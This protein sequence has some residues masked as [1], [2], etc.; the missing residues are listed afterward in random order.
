MGNYNTGSKSNSGCAAFLLILFFG[1]IIYTGIRFFSD[2]SLYKT[3]TSAYNANDLETAYLKYDKISDQFHIFDLGNY[4]KNAAAGVVACASREYKEAEKLFSSYKYQEAFSAF[5]ALIER[6]LEYQL[7]D[8]LSLAQE[9]QKICLE[10]IR[11]GIQD[12]YNKAKCQVVISD[13]KWMAEHELE[14]G[15]RVDLQSIQN[16]QNQCLDYIDRVEY[17]KDKNPSRP[18][19]SIADFITADPLDPLAVEAKKQ[20]RKYANIYGLEKI[21]SAKTCPILLEEYKGAGYENYLFRCGK[22]FIDAGED[23]NA[24]N[25][26]EQFVEK[27]PNDTR[28]QEVVDI[29]ADLLIASARSSGAGSLPAPDKAGKTKKGTSQYIVTNDTPYQLRLVFSGPEKKIVTIPACPTCIEYS[30]APISCPSEGPEETIV[31]MPGEYSLLAETATPE[32]VTPY[33]G[34]FTMDDGTKYELC[35]YIVQSIY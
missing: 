34:F 22:A 29:L 26:Y 5:E 18:G 30:F 24:I 2:M 9:K 3:A 1:A 19:D 4:R 16:L 27:Y 6:K 33:T 7:G 12:N 32:G 25:M 14:I 21:L 11:N 20:L 28:Y 13:A 10:H 17:S 35:F 15:N 23:W 8:Y 31:L